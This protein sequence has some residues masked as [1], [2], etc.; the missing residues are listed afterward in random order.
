MRKVVDEARSRVAQA[1]RAIDDVDQDRDLSTQGKERK[2]RKIAAQAIADFGASK[3]LAGA[4]EAVERMMGR[5]REK[6]GLAIKPA[7]N[8]HEAAIFAK[9]WDRMYE[10][11]GAARMVWLEKNGSDA[12]I[13]SALLTAPAC[14]SGVSDTVISFL[15][16]KVEQHFAPQIA[17]ARDA[18]LKAMKEAEQGWQKAIDEIGKRAGLTKVLMA[19]GA[20]L[21]LQRRNGALRIGFRHHSDQREMPEVY[22]CGVG[23]VATL[24]G[25]IG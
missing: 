9:I 5:W 8:I 1:W 16:K 7:S 4:R 13:A 25:R 6:M 24:G 19:H 23:V 15:R 20:I 3:G 17:A 14:L 11:Q 22:G 12:M 10:L 2:R 18:T 21:Q